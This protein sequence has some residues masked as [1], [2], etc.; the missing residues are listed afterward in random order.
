[1]LKQQKTQLTK[2]PKLR[3]DREKLHDMLENDIEP[4]QPAFANKW[5]KW[6]E[7]TIR[8]IEILYSKIDDDWFASY[9]KHVI[10]VLHTNLV[11]WGFGRQPA[12]LKPSIWF[13]KC[14][15]VVDVFQQNCYLVEALP[16]PFC[17]LRWNIPQTTRISF[18]WFENLRRP[19]FNVKTKNYTISK[20]SDSRVNYSIQ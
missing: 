15:T 1:M 16:L 17:P 2:Y 19:P 9:T 20:K 12:G 4:T 8:L 6:S 18:L 11:Y 5:S 14:S 10:Y 7:L 3:W 13:D